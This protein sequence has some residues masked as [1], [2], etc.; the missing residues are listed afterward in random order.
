MFV[1]LKRYRNEEIQT[2]HGLCQPPL[3]KK[4]AFNLVESR[5]T[6]HYTLKFR[7]ILHSHISE[8]D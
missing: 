3:L 2:L 1:A 4:D 5:I 6:K 8:V 7:Y